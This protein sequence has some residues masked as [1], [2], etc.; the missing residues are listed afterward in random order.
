MRIRNLS[1]IVQE[2]ESVLR[3]R[4]CQYILRQIHIVGYNYKELHRHRQRKSHLVNI[5]RC[6]YKLRLGLLHSNYYRYKQS[7]F[8]NL[9]L[10]YNELRIERRRKSRFQHNLQFGDIREL[11]TILDDIFHL[12]RNQQFL[13]MLINTGRSH[14]NLHHILR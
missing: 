12:N 8:R 11:H 2:L 14:M 4:Q 13:N 10:E 5:Q 1:D 6:F 9:N 3:K 7:L